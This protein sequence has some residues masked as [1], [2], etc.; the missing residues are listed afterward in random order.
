MIPEKLESIH[1]EQLNLYDTIIVDEGQDFK[2]F[3]YEVL[4][5]HLKGEGRFFV[6]L[7]ANQDIFNHYTQLPDQQKFVKFKLSRNCRNPKKVLQ[8]L[9]DNTGIP[10]ECFEDTPIGGC[11]IK[12]YDHS[13]S[14]GFGG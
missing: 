7:D 11:T 8:Y 2:E 12:K 9:T 3:W 1:T 14:D 10:F 13:K 6:F 4:E 5:R